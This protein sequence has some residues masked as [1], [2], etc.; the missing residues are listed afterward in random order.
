[1]AARRDSGSM[2]RRL[3]DKGFPVDL[4]ALDAPFNLTITSTTSIDVD[5]TPIIGFSQ[6]LK[7][8]VRE[9]GFKCELSDIAV[10]PSIHSPR[11]SRVPTPSF[12]SPPLISLETHPAT[13]WAATAETDLVQIQRIPPHKTRQPCKHRLSHRSQAQGS[14]RTPAITRQQSPQSEHRP[15]CPASGAACGSLRVS[16]DAFDSELHKRGCSCQ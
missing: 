16:A 1:M 2:L 13:A 6:R 4:D 8:I 12:H 10:F 5:A 15:G 9:S 14:V 7:E 3:A 11:M